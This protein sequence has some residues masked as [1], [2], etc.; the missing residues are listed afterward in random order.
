M[1]DDEV[2]PAIASLVRERWPGTKLA[3]LTHLAGDFSSRRYLRATLD[4]GGAPPTVVVMVLAGSG[5]PLS[6]EELGVFP[7]PPSELPFLDVHR[8]LTAIGAPVPAVHVAA[9]ERG[10]L[11][12]ADGGDVV[13]WDEAT[14]SADPE[15]LYR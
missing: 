10:L 2:R 12:L 1:S 13:L 7:E 15:A 9:V 6:S 3:T 14:A 8:L 11:I 4:G 5:L